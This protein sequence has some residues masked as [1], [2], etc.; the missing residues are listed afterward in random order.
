MKWYYAIYVLIIVICFLILHLLGNWIYDKWKGE[1]IY[2]PVIIR[3]DSVAVAQ[4]RVILA[5]QIQLARKEAK[6][7]IINNNKYY[8]QNYFNNLADS[9][10]PNYN[11]W[12]ARELLPDNNKGNTGYNIRRRTE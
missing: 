12:K 3:D 4:A 5:L 11:Y 10:L 7:E 6:Q 9:L 2:E 1:D 8:E